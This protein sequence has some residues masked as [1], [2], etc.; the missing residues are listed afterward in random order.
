[1]YSP[2]IHPQSGAIQ[3]SSKLQAPEK[4]Q[5]P[6]FNPRTVALPLELDVWNFSGAWSL[7][8]GASNRRCNCS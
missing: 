5:T 1:M 7:E 3:K 4:H 2:T 6:N 8:F